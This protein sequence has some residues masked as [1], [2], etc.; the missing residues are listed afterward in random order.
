MALRRLGVLNSVIYSLIDTFQTMQH[1]LRASYG[2]SDE[3]FTCD[4]ENTKFHGIGQGNVFALC[5]WAA[6]SL[7]MLEAMKD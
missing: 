5:I 2:D 7:V 4:G 3:Y 6:I 1:H